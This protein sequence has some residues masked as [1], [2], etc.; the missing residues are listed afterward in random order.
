[1]DVS[2]EYVEIMQSGIVIRHQFERYANFEPGPGNKGRQRGFVILILR[3]EN[4]LV[5]LGLEPEL[6]V[7]VG[8][9]IDVS[10]GPAVTA[11]L[12]LET[13]LCLRRSTSWCRADL[14]GPAVRTGPG[15]RSLEGSLGGMTA[16]WAE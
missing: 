6:V 15:C 3:E 2:E 13:H 8:C 1:M 14:K 5:D 10:N 7:Q 12:S 11:A 16:A 4:L 9:F